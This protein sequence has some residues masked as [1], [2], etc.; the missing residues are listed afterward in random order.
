VLA[1]VSV[2]PILL[3]AIYPRVLPPCAAGKRKRDKQ[4]TMIW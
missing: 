2:L 3:L 4:K 1:L